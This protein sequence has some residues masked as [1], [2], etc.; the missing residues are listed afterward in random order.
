MA[1]T[2][3]NALDIF[4]EILRRYGDTPLLRQKLRTILE[5]DNLGGYHDRPTYRQEDRLSPRMYSPIPRSR[6]VTS[7]SR[8][9]VVPPRLRR[10]PEGVDINRISGNRTAGDSNMYTMSELRDIADAMGISVMGKSKGQLA[11]EIHARLQ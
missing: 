11:D 1:Y 10:L 6:P 4:E 3:S 7:P 9:N 2:N 8:R 5:E